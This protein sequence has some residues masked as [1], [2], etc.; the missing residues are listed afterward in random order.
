MTDEQ[1]QDYLVLAAWRGESLSASSA[2]MIADALV[3]LGRECTA[4]LLRVPGRWVMIRRE[5]D[6]WSLSVWDTMRYR[7]LNCMC[8]YIEA[9][10]VR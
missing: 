10:E 2:G 6:T 8:L 9:E 1:V 7:P 3:E 5:W 4:D